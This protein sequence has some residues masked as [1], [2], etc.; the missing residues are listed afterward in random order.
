[1]YFEKKIV[2]LKIKHE[3]IILKYL[4]KKV[5]NKASNN[6]YKFPSSSKFGFQNSNC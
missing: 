1:M 4:I 3:G 2:K 6:I 5:K